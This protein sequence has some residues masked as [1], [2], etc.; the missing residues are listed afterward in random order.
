MSEEMNEFLSGLEQCHLIGGIE[1]TAN[2]LMQG[3][4]L[5]PNPGGVSKEMLHS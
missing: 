5:H 2:G 4:V 3:R 1:Y